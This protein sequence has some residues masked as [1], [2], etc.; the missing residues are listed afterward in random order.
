MREVATK[1]FHIFFRP[2]AAKKIPLERLVEERGAD[3]SRAGGARERRGKPVQ[4]LGAL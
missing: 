2:L 4:P 3:I 1:V